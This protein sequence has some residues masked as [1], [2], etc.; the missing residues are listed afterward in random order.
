MSQRR[1]W[2]LFLPEPVR[3]LPADLAVVVAGV[4]LTLVVTLTPGLAET[5][6]RDIAGLVF[7]LFLPGYALIAALFPERGPP[8]DAEDRDR[9]GGIDGIE[10]VALSFGTSIAVVP[11]LGLVLNFTPWGLRLGPILVTLS[12]F[13]LVATAFAATRRSALPEDERLVVPY[14]RWFAAARDEL[15]NPASRTDAML[16]VVLVVSVVLATASV[17]YAVAVPKDGESFTELYLLTED[18]NDELTADNYPEEL[19]RGEPAS[20]VLGVGNQEHRT[21]NYTVVTVLQRVEVSNNST[22]VLE[23]ERLRT[24]TPRLEHNETWHEPHEVRPTMTGERLR[25]TYL[26]YEGAPPAAPTADNAYR[27]VHLWVTVRAE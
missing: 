7:S 12:G 14:E 3:S 9:M 18:G 10:R 27:E 2:R 19:V 25:L 4:A 20:L 21:V 8:I 1:D 22:T 13:T 6:L 26:L 24:F 17:G 11:L 16:N 15:F 23:S 5:P